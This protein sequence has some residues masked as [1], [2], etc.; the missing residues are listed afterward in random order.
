MN[1]TFKE[2]PYFTEKW[3]SLGLTDDDLRMLENILLKDPKTGDAITGTGGLRKIRIPIENC[4]KRSGGRVIY[5]DVQV[6]ECI[7]L[8]DVYLKN[9]KNDLNEKEKKLLKKL[10][11]VLKEE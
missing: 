9:E 1:R 11:T 7:Y 4:G 6:K 8:I 3:I 10:V 5:V 2:T